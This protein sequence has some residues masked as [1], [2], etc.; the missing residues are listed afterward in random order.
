[1][2]RIRCEEGLERWPDSHESEWKSATDR[3]RGVARHLQEETETWD[4]GSSQDP[5]GVALAVT[6]NT[7]DMEP[8]EATYCS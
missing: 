3:G 8:E 2:F 5:M 6:N 1:M 7:R 4:K